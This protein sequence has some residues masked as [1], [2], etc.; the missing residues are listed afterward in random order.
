[1]KKRCLFDKAKSLIMAACIGLSG[2]LISFSS[3]PVNVA[4]AENTA[5]SIETETAKLSFV[6]SRMLD[7]SLPA[8]D[9]VGRDYVLVLY[10]YE[11]YTTEP[12]SP[13]QDFWPRVYQNGVELSELSSRNANGSEDAKMV[14]AFFK[15]VIKGGVLEFGKAYELTDDSPLTVILSENGA[16]EVEPVAIE[17]NIGEDVSAAAAEGTSEEAPAETETEDTA[18]SAEEFTVDQLKAALDG[19]WKHSSGDGFLFNN[20]EASLLEQGNPKTTGT[21]SFDTEKKNLDITLQSSDGQNVSVHLPY[22]TDNGVL[23]VFNNKGE[24]LVKDGDATIGAAAGGEAE[25]APEAAADGGA[26]AAA[27]NSNTISVEELEAELNAQPLQ[28]LD[29]E[30]TNSDDSRFDTSLRMGVLVPH[31]I[32]NSAGKVK[33]LLVYCAAWD[34]NNL[35]IML[36]SSYYNATYTPRI[37]LD[38]VNLVEGQKLN[39]DDADTFSLVPFDDTLTVAKAKTII[40]AYS[41]FDGNVWENPYLQQWLDIYG[42]KELKEPVNYSDPAIVQKVQEALNAA[43]FDCGTPDGAAGAKTHEAI[44]AYQAANGLAETGEIDA[45]LLESMQISI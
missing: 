19:T 35:P 8:G 43:G 21:Y 29:T 22:T 25:A 31:V 33:D 11:N 24:A 17:A 12:K 42:G 13:Q 2:V 23:T 38:G 34:A 32:N 27:E 44:A 1:M 26:D 40:A 10:T 6:G 7:E 4:A 3:M 15:T 14:E 45:A 20:G 37:V 36:K 9:S 30:V 18:G 39:E 41:D 16:S 5:N 28:V